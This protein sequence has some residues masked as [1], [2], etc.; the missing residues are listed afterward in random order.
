MGRPSDLE[1]GGGRFDSRLAQAT[2]FGHV[3]MVF[4]LIFTHVWTGLGT[5]LGRVWGTFR[6]GL[7]HFLVGSGSLFGEIWDVL[8]CVWEWLGDLFT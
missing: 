4:S 7:G 5:L 2:F 6:S 8:G 1:A 3:G